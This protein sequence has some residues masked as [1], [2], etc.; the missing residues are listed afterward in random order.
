M[1]FVGVDVGGK[2]IGLAVGEEETGVAVPLRI[3]SARDDPDADARAVLE[4]V[5]NHD[6]DA[7]VVG[8]PLNM[9]GSE[10]GQAN[11]AR[12]FGAVLARLS[13]KE[14][15]YFDE[16][17]SSQAADELLQPAGFTRARHRARQD[18]V[19][20]QVILQGFLDARREASPH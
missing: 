6:P 11:L 5:R 7:F 17:L 3:V 19:A 1:R 16:R 9:D 13:G 8:L 2:R 14:V 18:A 10:G 4:A 15:F 12:S 20:A